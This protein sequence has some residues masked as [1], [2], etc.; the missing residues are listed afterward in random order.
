MKF[1]GPVAIEYEK[2]GDTD[3]DMVKQVAYARSLA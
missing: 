2:E 3:P 1:A